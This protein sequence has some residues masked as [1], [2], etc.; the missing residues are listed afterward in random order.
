MTHSGYVLAAYLA[1]AI[2]LLGLVAGVLL[3]LAVQK[4]KLARLEASAGRRRTASP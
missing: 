1:A 3:D 4:R 2:I